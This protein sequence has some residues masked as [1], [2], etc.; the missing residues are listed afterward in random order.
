MIDDPCFRG[1]WYGTRRLLVNAIFFGH[2]VQRT[3]P[4]EERSESEAMDYDHGHAH[5]R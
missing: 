4:I 3:G 2:T 5:D 1:V